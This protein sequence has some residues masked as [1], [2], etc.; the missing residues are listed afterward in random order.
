MSDVSIIIPVVRPES[1]KRAAAAALHNCGIDRSRVQVITEID[2]DGIGCPRMVNRLAKKGRGRYVCFLGDDTEAE[3]G[4]LA[5]ALETMAALPDG[6]GLVG[7]NTE[8][9]SPCA[10]WI[11]DRRMLPLF[12]GEWFH[13]GYQHNFPDSEIM[14]IAIEN[15]RWAWCSMAKIKHHHPMSGQDVD[16]HHERAAEKWEQDRR[17]Y[18]RRKRAR[19]GFLLGIAVPLVDSKIDAPFHISYMEMDKPVPYRY[20]RPY[21]P[22]GP[23]RG[24]LADARNALVREA[25]MAGCSHLLMLDSDQVYPKNTLTKLLQNIG[26]EEVDICGVSVH[27]RYDPFDVIMLKGEHGSYEPLPESEWYDQGLVE[28]DATGTG[29]LMMKM[30]VFDDIDEPWFKWPADQSEPGEDIYFC[31]R[32]RKAGFRIFVDTDLPVDHLIQFGVNRA[33]RELYKQHVR[34]ENQ[35][36]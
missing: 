6:W 12:G 1:G 2:Q 3:P 17:L 34:K 25:M 33:F 20:Y 7:L 35:N 11:A 27:R 23:W 32:A 30:E 14:D 24:S 16:G 26:Q 29:C 5:A 31:G 18:V 19:I 4:W 8:S 36:G 22:H 9:S 21:Q 13:E 28:V 10:H 15:E